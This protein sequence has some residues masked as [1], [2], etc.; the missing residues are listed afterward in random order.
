MSGDPRTSTTD[1]VPFSRLPIP[2][3]RRLLGHLSALAIFIA[4]SI[5]NTWPLAA[6]L[7]R[8]VSDPG[9]PLINAWILDWDWYATLHQ[10]LS[11]FHAN[12]FYPAKYALA[13]SE[14]LY[15]LAMLTFPLRAIGIAPLTTYNLAM[16]AGFA[17]CGFAAYLLCFRLTRS[18]AAGLAG[19]V[20]YAFVPFRFVHLAHLQHVWG[21]WLP[22]LLFALLLY[23]ETPT[24]KR[25]MFFAAVFV[26]NGLTNIHYL[27]F[28]ALAAAITA[29]LLSPR[30]SWRELLIATF[31]A[32]AILAPF[33]Y[34][35]AAASSMYGMQRS[36]DDVA[37][38]S[39]SLRDWLPHDREPELRLYPGAFALIVAA[40]G[41][42]ARKA[43]ARW[44]ALLW[45][46]IGFV[47]SLGLHTQFHAF[48]YGAVPGFRAIRVPARWAVIAYVGLAI[49]IALATA[50]LAKRNRIAAFIVP[51]A[52]VV[53]L[54]H[55]PIRWFLIDP[56]PAPV[57]T[58]LAKQS[59]RGGVIELPISQESD[60]DVMFRST[61]HHKPIVN[62][63][64]GFAPSQRTEIDALQHSDPI[65]D[66]LLDRLIEQDV[67]LLILHADLL[68][69]RAPRFRDWLRRELDRNRLA[70]V[71]RFDTKVDGDFVFRIAPR[72][73]ST[74]TPEL[75]AL[76]DG[77][78]QCGRA[79]MG[80]LD[81]PPPEFAFP[82]G[83]IFSGWVV[84]HDGIGSVDLWFNNR[85]T[86]ITAKLQA[87]QQ[88]ES[89][90]AGVPNV[91]RARFVATLYERPPEIREVTDV[92][93][94]VTDAHGLKTV[95]DDRWISWVDVASAPHAK[96]Q[97]D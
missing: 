41:F 96:K 95:F 32:I 4:L 33:L 46:V 49:L 77:K 88:L 59:L 74:R 69:D 21:G 15:G 6:N 25:A 1:V 57:Y 24:R 3:Y 73:S 64:S 7:S 81:F 29:L 50:M 40:I 20:F 97:E 12:V 18:F 48:L 53:A 31:V 14:N 37:R 79:L 68:G 39:A 9:D 89:R 92:Q 17:F 42:F 63:V 85:R 86:K 43:Y 38:F 82:R 83:A 71:G 56:Q 44:L 87:E 45:I 67:E 62:G 94:E 27:F 80:A 78:P 10:P 47:G 72:S 90:C 11:L 52:F 34:P 26:M 22:M 60:Y 5:A 84:S 28:G 93:P 51:I 16:L 30:E 2:D 70:Y 91:T 13:F 54:W 58:W 36:I 55:A 66:A 65:P 19:G 75:E 23:A 35:Y 61:T 8:A 76:L